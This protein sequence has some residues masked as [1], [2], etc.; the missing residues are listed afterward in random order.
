M[1]E[2]GGDGKGKRIGSRR[3]EVDIYSHGRAG[4]GSHLVNSEAI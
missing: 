4:F 3:T 1:R 2:I